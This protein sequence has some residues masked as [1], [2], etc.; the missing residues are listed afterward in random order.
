MLNQLPKNSVPG[1]SFPSLP[2]GHAASVLA[3][4]Y[5][6][7]A[8]EKLPPDAIAFEQFKQLRCLLDYAKQHSPYIKN[9]FSKWALPQTLDYAFL[10][11]LPIL[12]RDKVK[13]LGE[14]LYCKNPPKAHGKCRVVETSGSTSTPVK[15]RV[16]EIYDFFWRAF[17][18]RD[19]AW[20]QRDLSKHLAAI[21]WSAGNL[22]APPHGAHAQGWGA[23]TDLAYNSGKSS[24]LNISATLEQQWHWLKK[25]QPNYLISFPSNLAALA[26]YSIKHQLSL[27]SL[28]QVRTIGEKLR[29]EQRALIKQ[30][31][32]VNTVDIYTCEEAGYIALQC[33]ENEHYHVQSENVIVEILNNE[34]QPCGIGEVGRVVITSLQNYATP[35]IRYELGDQA[36]WGEPCSCGRTLPVIKTIHGRERSRLSLPD[37]RSEFPF[38]GEHGEIAKAI[39]K[40]PKEIQYFQESLEH[41][42]IRL[43]MDK[44]TN[45][46]ENAIRAL[47]IK[48][49]GHPFTI[50]FEYHEQELPRNRRGKFEYFIN[51]IN[52]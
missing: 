27:P 5:Q 50:S 25:T 42:I 38:L 13:A 21:R 19:H 7:L 44:L 23:I 33:P 17:A 28:M 30:A 24:F 20:H 18:L 46:E 48:N 31:W 51:G 16:T 15:V 4:Q 37:G 26:R 8:S 10:Q 43:R 39:G 12:S 47:A 45:N 32:G 11:S 36:E 1:A 40:S 6:L 52:Q 14:D 41:I 49:F 2:S 29:P 35:L 3:M 34:N 9:L 22:G